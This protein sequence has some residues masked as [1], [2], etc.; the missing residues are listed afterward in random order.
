MDRL[1]RLCD[2]SRRAVHHSLSGL[3][4]RKLTAGDCNNTIVGR[5]INVSLPF[6]VHGGR[7]MR[8][9]RGVTRVTTSVIGSKSRVFLSTDAATIFITGTLGR[10]RHL[11]IIAGSVRVLLRLSSM[12][13]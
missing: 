1:D 10:G 4:G 13:N 2:I 12:S 11:A 9:G 8:K 3:R 7:G 6:G 5:S